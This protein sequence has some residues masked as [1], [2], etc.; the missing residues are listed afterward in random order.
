MAVDK[1]AVPLFASVAEYAR[2]LQEGRYTALAL[3]ES[4][5]AQAER[6]GAL[7]AILHLD[8]GSILAQ[9]RPSDERRRA[10]QGRGVLDG[11]PG[12]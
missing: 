5:L 9:T 3:A 2:D 6:Q 4:C 11:S 1:K 8:G 10:G 7:N 12:S